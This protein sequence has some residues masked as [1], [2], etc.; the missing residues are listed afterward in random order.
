MGVHL[1]TCDHC[2]RMLFGGG[3]LTFARPLFASS[4]FILREVLRFSRFGLGLDCA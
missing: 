3:N 4:A 1:K 2:D